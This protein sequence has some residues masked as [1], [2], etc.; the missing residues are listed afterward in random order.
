[1]WK[2]LKILRKWLWL[3]GNEIFHVSIPY[4]TQRT[5]F[6]L[7]LKA[8]HALVCSVYYLDLNTNTFA[9]VSLNVTSSFKSFHWDKSYLIRSYSGPYFPAFGLDTER[10]GV[11]PA[12]MWEI[13]TRITLNTDTFYTVFIISCNSISWLFSDIASSEEFSKEWQSVFI[14]RYRWSDDQFSD[15][16]EYIS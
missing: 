13:W 11:Y 5:S 14:F 12:Q 8:F 1:M 7:I 3:L 4:K 9:E 16:D 15:F 10:Y 2:S 6:C